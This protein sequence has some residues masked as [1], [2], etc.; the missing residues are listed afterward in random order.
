MTIQV[1]EQWSHKDLCCKL[2]CLRYIIDININIDDPKTFYVVF[3]VEIKICIAVFI[4]VKIL[5]ARLYQ[6]YTFL[7]AHLPDYIPKK[8]T[9]QYILTWCLEIRA[10]PKKVCGQI[11]W[12]YTILYTKEADLNLENVIL[13]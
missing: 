6:I 3:R 9:L 7:G 1:R 13:K 10:V 11:L 12:K 4:F 8:S 2:C 5:F